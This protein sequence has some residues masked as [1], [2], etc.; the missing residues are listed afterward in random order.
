MIKGVRH[1]PEIKYVFLTT[2]LSLQ[3]LFL[4]LLSRQ[5]ITVWLRLVSNSSAAC[6]CSQ[7]LG[8]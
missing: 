4:R 7:V 6:L 5:D 1:L 8:F 2:K 3:P